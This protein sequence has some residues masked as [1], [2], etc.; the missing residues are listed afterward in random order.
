MAGKALDGAGCPPGWLA[1]YWDH[2]HGARGT[3]GSCP[4]SDK[5][6]RKPQAPAHGLCFLEQSSPGCLSG[7]LLLWRLFTYFI[8]YSEIKFFS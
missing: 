3:W 6:S 8:S 4:R 5:A 7:Y 2:S 1:G